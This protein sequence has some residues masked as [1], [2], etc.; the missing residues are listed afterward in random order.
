[1]IKNHTTKRSKLDKS[2]ISQHY[3]KIDIQIDLAQ[4]LLEVIL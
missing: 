2:F 1:M 4:D 3:F